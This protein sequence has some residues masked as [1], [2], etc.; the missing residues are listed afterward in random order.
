MNATPSITLTGD[1]CGLPIYLA[2][3]LDPDTQARYEIHERDTQGLSHILYAGAV[4]GSCEINIAPLIRSR[5]QD[6]EYIIPTSATGTFTIDTQS[7]TVQCLLWPDGET[8][9][10]ISEMKFVTRG[11]VPP[12][13]IKALDGGNIFAV[14]RPYGDNIVVRETELMPVMFFAE[15]AGFSIR[16]L[17]DATDLITIPR[18]P[19]SVLTPQWIAFDILR[20]QVAQTQGRLCN[21][22]DIG[23]ETDGVWHR[24]CRFTIEAAKTD[25]NRHTIRY[26]NRHGAYERLEICG[27]LTYQGVT[28]EEEGTYLTY[29]RPTATYATNRPRTPQTLDITI[30]ATSESDERLTLLNEALASEEIWL[31]DLNGTDRKVIAAS[32]TQG[33][34]P[35][36]APYAYEVKMRLSAAIYVLEQEITP[37]GIVVRTHKPTFK[38]TYN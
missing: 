27:T 11:C 29:D 28:A 1:T 10:L 4:T 18:V 14:Q 13:R 9:P 35:T 30:A 21:C 23:S 12:S 37:D 33:E 24:W 25:P 38:Q 36:S 3:T 8:T 5:L 17:G 6:P 31:E 32:L 2:I 15:R 22:F 34:L 26:V 7:I 20:Q 19:G 16:C